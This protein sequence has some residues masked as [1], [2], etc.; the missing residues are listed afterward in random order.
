MKT[1][2]EIIE[3]LKGLNSPLADMPRLMPYHVPTGYFSKLDAYIIDGVK[4]TE[5]P[6]YT[7][8]YTKAMPYE[9]PMGYFDTLPDMVAA[10]VNEQNETISLT[11]SNPFAMPAGYFDAL[12]QQ[13][14]QAVKQAETPKTKTIPLGNRVWKNLRWAAAA[15]LLMGIGFGSYKMLQPTT[16]PLSTEQQLAQLPPGTISEYVQ[17][18][19]DDFDT[20]LIASVMPGDINVSPA[21]LSDEEI[22]NY[23]DEVGWD[24]DNIN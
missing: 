5:L 15:I 13:M 18:N 4:A 9:V 19:I 16:A 21:Q 8:P 23:L 7:L 22:T 20:D 3:E 24:T 1:A 17:Q 6:E 12:P 2:N 14:L 11:K 10:L